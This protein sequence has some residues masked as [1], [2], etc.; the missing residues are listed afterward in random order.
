MI[1]QNDIL[2]IVDKFNNKLLI[3]KTSPYT[4]KLHQSNEN[5]L[6]DL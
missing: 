2:E 3:N 1:Q 6:R 5:R 4:I